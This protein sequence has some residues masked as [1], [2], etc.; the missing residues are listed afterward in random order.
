M[1]T[2]HVRATMI[3]QRSRHLDV[4]MSPKLA[5]ALQSEGKKNCCQ[6]MNENTPGPRGSWPSV[7]WSVQMEDCPLVLDTL[8]GTPPLLLLWDV[9]SVGPIT[10]LLNTHSPTQNEIHGK[11]KRKTIIRKAMWQMPLISQHPFASN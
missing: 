6:V 11:A 5:Q 9:F 10:C 2:A 3:C 8:G 1:R 7:L 4:Q